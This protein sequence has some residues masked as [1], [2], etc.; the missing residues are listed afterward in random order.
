MVVWLTSSAFADDS[1]FDPLLDARDISNLE[2]RGEWKVTASD[3]S[4]YYECLKCVSEVT[5]TLAVIAPYNIE[6]Y[7]SYHDKYLAERASFCAEIVQE[8]R[9]RCIGNRKTG[10][11]VGLLKGFRSTHEID[12]HLV[13]EIVF[14]YQNRY[15]GP[16]RSPE[17]IKVT[18][19]SSRGATI[20]ED[21]TEMLRMHMARLTTAY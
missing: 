21:V 15:F 7:T 14:F 9:G 19:K 20:P 4:V 13:T 8:F 2:E 17:L 5:A 3:S 12:D 16:V 10:W 11:R 18:I 1:R 6:N